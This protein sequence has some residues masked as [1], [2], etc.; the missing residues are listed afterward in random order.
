[1]FSGRIPAEDSGYR[2]DGATLRFAGWCP[3]SKHCPG[4]Y[5]IEWGSGCSS[6]HRRGDQSSSIMASAGSSGTAVVERKLARLICSAVTHSSG[7]L[8]VAG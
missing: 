5:P 3:F 2:R 8:L 6:E 7:V 1:M 4:V